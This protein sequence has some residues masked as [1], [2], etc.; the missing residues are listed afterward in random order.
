MFLFVPAYMDISKTTRKSKKLRY[1]IM[2]CFANEKENTITVL[3][4]T[5]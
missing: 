1:F 3:T 5:G 2:T 4:L